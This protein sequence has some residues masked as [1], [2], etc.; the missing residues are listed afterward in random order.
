VR[1]VILF[2]SLYPARLAVSEDDGASWSPLAPLGEWG[3]IVVMGSVVPLDHAGQYRAFF[4]DDGRFFQKAGRPEEPTVFTLYTTRSTDGGLTW[5]KPQAVYASA[6]VHLCEPGVIRSPDGQQLAMLLRENARRRNSHV[7]FSQDEGATWTDPRELPATL[8][9]DRHVGK[10]TSDGRLFISFRDRTPD[11]APR[12]Y[13][14]PHEGD[15]VAWVGT[16]DDIV[17]GRPGQ[18]RVR[19]KDN[20]KA[21]DCAYPGVEVL[22]DGTVVTTTYGHWD[23]ADLYGNMFPYILSVR[24]HLDELDARVDSVRPS[25]QVPFQGA[26]HG[27]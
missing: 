20:K 2:S 10:Y 22:A 9:G 15:W 1:R 3:G 5:D 27:H 21:W 16:Y 24:L 6:E 26:Q 17:L 13:D 23:A 14:S 12:D 25:D 11:H 19:L 7:M 8:T 4:H 18:Y